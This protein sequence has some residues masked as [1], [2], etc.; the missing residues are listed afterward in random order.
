[1]IP[2]R[3]KKYKGREEVAREKD[4]ESKEKCVHV[5]RRDF[6]RDS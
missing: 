6:D 2:Q 1:M 4:E 5:W 3:R